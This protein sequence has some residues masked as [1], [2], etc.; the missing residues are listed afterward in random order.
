MKP[1]SERLDFSERLAR[2][3]RAD[4][5]VYVSLKFCSCYAI[6]GNTFAKRFERLGIPV[7]EISSDYSES[8]LG[9]LRTRIGAFLE[10]LKKGE[11]DVRVPA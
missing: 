10:L 2:E 9:Q 1:L 8:D 6:T 4:A 7:L 11:T 5:I 3:Y